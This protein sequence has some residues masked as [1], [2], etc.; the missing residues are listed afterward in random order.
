MCPGGKKTGLQQTPGNSY[1]LARLSLESVVLDHLSIIT[2][3][4][5]FYL[6][7]DWDANM[8]HTLFFNTQ[9]NIRLCNTD[10]SLLS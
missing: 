4:H 1:V 8:Y 7:T 2:L 9:A 6:N 5:F 10:T 3:T